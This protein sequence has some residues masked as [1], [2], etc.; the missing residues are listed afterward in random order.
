MKSNGGAVST[1]KRQTKKRTNT[2]KRTDGEDGGGKIKNWT[3]RGLGRPE[4]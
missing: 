2:S 4:I 3:K 1:T